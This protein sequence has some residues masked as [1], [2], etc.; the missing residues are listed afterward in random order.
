M[1]SQIWESTSSNNTHNQT[2]DYLELLSWRAAELAIQMDTLP[3]HPLR[4]A[5]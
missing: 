4:I 3:S 5:L 1:L 2:W